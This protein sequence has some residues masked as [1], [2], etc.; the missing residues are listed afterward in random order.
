MVFF[1]TNKELKIQSLLL[2]I[3]SQHFTA[4]LYPSVIKTKGNLDLEGMQR[5]MD[6]KP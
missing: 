5:K 2:E 1:I 4:R 6:H 3:T